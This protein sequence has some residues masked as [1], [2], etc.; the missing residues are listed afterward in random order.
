MYRWPYEI[1][2]ADLVTYGYLIANDDDS[3]DNTLA[4]IGFR[5]ASLKCR[6]LWPYG[7]SGCAPRG[8]TV[9]MWA[10]GGSKSNSAVLPTYPSA[11][12]KN[13]SEW[14]FATGNYKTQAETFYDENGNVNIFA[15]NGNIIGSA[16]S[17]VTLSA[18]GDINAS[19][20]NINMASSADTT[21]ECDNLTITATDDV[22]INCTNL[23][24]NASGAITLN[25]GGQTLSVS[26]SGMLNNGT[27]VGEG[28][29][30]GPG[31]YEDAENRPI[32]GES[33][34]VV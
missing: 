15:P 17:D 21:I 6:V 24:V 11:R 4:K 25:A 5:G 20:T 18:V 31:T 28:H 7:L 14:E 32:T 33:G 23:T 29:K 22:T 10:I 8:S 12:R 9:M 2:F 27:D 13:M 1:G 19:A 16:A 34:V 26:S 30:H 3:Q